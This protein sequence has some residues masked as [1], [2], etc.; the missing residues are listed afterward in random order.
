[1][2]VRNKNYNLLK[3]LIYFFG[4]QGT[5]PMD[6]PSLLAPLGW[7]LIMT[8]I[9]YISWSELYIIFRSCEVFWGR[10][11]FRLDK[12]FC[13]LSF[14]SWLWD[15]LIKTFMNTNKMIFINAIFPFQI[16]EFQ[17]EIISPGCSWFIAHL[18]SKIYNL[19]FK[20]WAIK[21]MIPEGNEIKIR[22]I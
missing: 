12:V 10:I 1:M 7:F 4:C 11:N 13:N 8:P 20:I 21:F 14:L 2:L 9:S 3:I 17:D 22:Y 19:W 18:H 6:W 16:S 15:Q 5:I